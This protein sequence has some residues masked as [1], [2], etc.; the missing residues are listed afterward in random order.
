MM[1]L[2]DC[3]VSGHSRDVLC[4]DLTGE[5]VVSGGQDTRVLVTRLGLP[6]QFQAVHQVS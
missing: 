2:E 6:Q 1:R 4:H 5:V 3:L